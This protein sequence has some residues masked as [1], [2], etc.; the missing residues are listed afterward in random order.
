MNSFHVLEF[1]C[2]LNTLY[3]KTAKIMKL[4]T[5]VVLLLQVKLG[6]LIH[7]KVTYS[8]INHQSYKNK[9]NFW[10]L[11]IF[12]PSLLNKLIFFST[13]SKSISYNFK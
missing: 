3:H 6:F 8:T 11:G 5:A 10:T 13:L 9:D 4:H 2:S 1:L 7:L 12:F